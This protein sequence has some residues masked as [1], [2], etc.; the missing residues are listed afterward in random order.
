MNR[1]GN[2][3]C[4]TKVRQT[5]RGAETRSELDR[6]DGQQTRMSRITGKKPLSCGGLVMAPK[7]S[8]RQGRGQEEEGGRKGD[9][10]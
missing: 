4:H 3:R 2:Q 8:R 5:V 7:R 1:M 9:G 10:D 6:R